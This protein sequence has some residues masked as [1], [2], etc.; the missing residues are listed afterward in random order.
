MIAM[1]SL[2]YFILIM[3]LKTGKSER[4]GGGDGVECCMSIEILMSVTIP[5]DVFRR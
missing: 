2:I 4:M 5:S 3:P 1:P